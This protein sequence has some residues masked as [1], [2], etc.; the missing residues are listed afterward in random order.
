MSCPRSSRTHATCTCVCVLG[1]LPR[2]N[3]ARDGTD[4]SRGR[5]RH[6]DGQ[7]DSQQQMDEILGTQNAA[8]MS[9]LRAE[10][11]DGQFVREFDPFFK[12]SR[13]SLGE[14]STFAFPLQLP[15]VSQVVTFLEVR[16][17]LRRRSPRVWVS[18]C[19]FP[20]ERTLIRVKRSL[21]NH[22]EILISYFPQGR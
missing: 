11:P 13:R 16:E 4:R 9:L 18:V 10:I 5:H 2:I 1:S 19:L 17:V 3:N 8:I 14:Y 22:H 12:I 6:T 15:P 20:S 7:T 21:E